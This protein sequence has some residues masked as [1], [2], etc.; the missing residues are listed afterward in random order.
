MRFWQVTADFF[1]HVLHPGTPAL[2][3]V[4]FDLSLVADLRRLLI[5][6][7]M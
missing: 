6:E 1:L 5:Q 2:L 3:E 7:W 4:L